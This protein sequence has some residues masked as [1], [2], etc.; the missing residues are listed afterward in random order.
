MRLVKR[1]RRQLPTAL[2]PESGDTEESVAEVL[3]VPRHYLVRA[4]LHSDGVRRLS[5]VPLRALGGA[6]LLVD[7]GPG[8]RREL[9]LV[10]AAS[11][12]NRCS[13]DG[14][15]SLSAHVP[16]LSHRCLQEGQRCRIESPLQLG[17]RSAASGLDALLELYRL[18]PAVG[19]A[20]ILGHHSRD[21]YRGQRAVD[22]RGD[23]SVPAGGQCHRADHLDPLLRSALSSSYLWSCSR[24]LSG[25]CGVS[26]RTAGWR[27]WSSCESATEKELPRRP[28]RPR[29]TAFSASPAVP[30]CR[31]S[32]PE[33][34]TRT[35]SVPSSPFLTTRLLAVTVA[36]L[37]VVMLLA[38]VV[39][40]PLEE[41]ANPEVTP[42]PA[43]A[44]WYFLGL[45]ELVGYS[46]LVG[47]V[48]IPGIVLLGLA[49]IPYLDREQAGIGFWFTD[50]PGRRWAVIGTVWGLYGPWAAWASRFCSPCGGFPDHREPALLR[51][52]QSR[53]LAVAALRRALLR[54]PQS[55]VLHPNAAIATFCAFIV[56]F[57]LLTYTGTA[58]RG[59]NWEFYWPWQ[60]WPRHP[61]PF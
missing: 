12:P 33:Q 7:Q 25:T 32:T 44:P 49:L 18:P 53:D 46:A 48:L 52:G 3:D 23:P 61:I 5:D 9:R 1:R 27:S 38:L 22:R 60:A 17:S 50:G 24:S 43:K 8:L 58:L 13:S 57:V 37:V 34:S 21:K 6:S 14:R 41:A 36:T 59:P 47:G 56:A 39:P 10:P 55:H 2:V 40:A 15:C 26:A 51:P 4:V 30:R 28:P 11:S 35:N 19:P 42:N 54:Q 16:G 29:P 20:G 45:Q 31:C